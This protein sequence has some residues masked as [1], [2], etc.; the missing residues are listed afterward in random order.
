MP[1]LKNYVKIQELKYNLYLVDFNEV[2]HE[3]LSNLKKELDRLGILTTEDLPQSDYN[4]LLHYFTLFTLCKA[5]NSLEHKKYTI[6][7]VNESVVNIAVLKF[8]KEIKKY[9][10]FLLYITNT[11]YNLQDTAVKTEITQS[12]KEF[13]YSI[14][15]SKYSFNKIKKY[16]IK[17]GLDNLVTSFKL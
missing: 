2:E 4:K 12:L 7:Y 10:P 13:R 8:I 11:P 16:C 5:Y 3:I 6:F 1:Y 15:F 17:S 9:F 14:D